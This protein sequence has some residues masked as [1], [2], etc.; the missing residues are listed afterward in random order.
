MNEQTDTTDTKQ[1]RKYKSYTAE[2]RAEII[3]YV[4]ENGM[5][6]VREKY[7]VWPMSVQYWMDPS[8][9]EHMSEKGKKRHK[10]NKNK[11]PEYTKKRN[12]YRLHRKKTGVDKVKYREWLSKLTP[13]QLEMRSK[14][15]KQHRLDNLEHYKKKSRARTQADKLS[16]KSREK[17]RT[18]KQYKLKCNLREHVRQ[19]VKYATGTGKQYNK[20]WFSGNHPG[21]KYLGCTV[22]EFV[23]Y[24][25]SKFK[26]GMSWAN[27]GRG[28]NCWHL[29]HI[30]P[31]A[32][33]KDVNDE[34]F[35]KKVCHY[36]NYQPLWEPENH[37][38]QDK[39]E[40][41]ELQDTTINDE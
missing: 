9:R 32:H 18:D 37:A 5:K 14:S 8:L 38:K 26:E 27:H 4:K 11:N 15:I 10:T 25:E 16:G 41:E 34:E 17:Y 30:R 3:A 7:G 6:D 24:I 31:L 35:V 23:K 40:E 12:Q 13:E 39:W 20:Q 21:L 19:A 2:Q 28:S 33:I 36:T 22:E 29:D 1:F